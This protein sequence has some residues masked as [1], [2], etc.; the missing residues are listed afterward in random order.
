MSKRLKKVP[1]RRKREKKTD[2]RK[3]LSLLK[4]GKPR[5]VARRA[6]NNTICQIV[7]FDKKGDK[8]KVSASSAE[9]P[10]FNWNINRGN[11]PAS[12]LTG[13]L[14]AVRAKSSGI[15]SAVFDIGLFEGKK[16]SRIFA[17]L[18][19]AVDAGLDIPH[20]E[21]AFPPEER[22]N[23]SHIARY[24]AK[25]KPSKEKYERY[26]SAYIKTKTDPESVPEIFKNAKS[27]ILA[28]GAK[29]K[30]KNKAEPKKAAAKPKSSK[31]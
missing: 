16:G 29:K 17:A 19:G 23:G 8:T 13:L 11:I 22:L 10:S 30:G 5:F 2:Y 12:Y 24:A 27:K 14:C 18:K 26:F 1:H 6:N 9:L 15:D 31:K 21:E 20:S 4:S 3:R 7:Y 25:L 28:E